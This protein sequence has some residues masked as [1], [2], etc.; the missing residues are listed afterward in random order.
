[1]TQ[2]EP[3]LI[4]VAED[5]E[6]NRDLICRRLARRGFRVAAVCNGREAVARACEIP[7]DII[8]MD[9][10]MPV[11][12]GFGAIEAIRAAMPHDETPIVALTAHATQT[13]E[14]RC[15]EAGFDA[16][17]TKPIDF[18]GLLARMADLGIQAPDGGRAP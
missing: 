15:R 7:A 3:A 2:A 17:V 4:L 9:L 5:N 18:K 10:E 11:L 16:F 12:S 6:A 8:L 14:Q 1:M 13:L